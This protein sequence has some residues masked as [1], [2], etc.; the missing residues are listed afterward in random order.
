[1]PGHQV[2]FWK[3]AQTASNLKGRGAKLAERWY[4]P[5]V[6]IGHEWDQAASRD[7][8]WVSYGGR[9][10]LVAGTHLR[11]AEQE[12]CLSHDKFIDE[13]K[14]AFDELKTPTF[15]YTDVRREQVTPGQVMGNVT[16]NSGTE[17]L[18]PES[19]ENL[20]G[21]LMSRLAGTVPD[22]GILYRQ[23]SQAPSAI[24]SLNEHGGMHEVGG[25][26][27]SGGPSANVPLATPRTRSPAV[28]SPSRNPRG[29]DI[30]N[31]D[32][33]ASVAEPA[34][35]PMAPVTPGDP[36]QDV[37]KVGSGHRDAMQA[38]KDLY[39]NA[40]NQRVFS[41][42]GNNHVLIVDELRSECYFLKWKTFNKMQRK[43]RE[44]DPRYFD[45]AE[46]L[47][48]AKSDAKE[49]QSFLDTGAVEVVSP[50]LARDI[51]QKRIFGRPMRFVRTNKNKEENGD[52][53]AKSRIV[54]PGD[55]DPDGDIP[56]EA[57]GFRTD[58]PT[59]PQIAFH[60]LCSQACLKKRQLG[61]LDCKTAFLT[62]RKHDRDIYCRPPK[63]GLPGV[64]PG[65]LL[66]IV[67]GAYG[68][69]EA[70]RLWYLKARD[71]LLDAG[72][73]EMQTA[74]ACFVLHDR[75]E[76]EPVNVGMLVLHVDDACYAG[77]GPMFEKAMEHIRSKFTIGKEEHG[78]FTFLG[79]RVKQ[80][81][82]FSVEIDQHDYV[83]ALERVVVAR[84][85]RQQ[86]TSPL[87]SKELHDYRSLVGQL[88]W[89]AR[90]TMP[91]LAYAVS[92]LQQKVAKATVG[93]L[94]HANNVLNVAKRSVQQN[95][96]LNFRDIGETPRMELQHSHRPTKKS[97]PGRLVKGLGMA[98][99]H[100]ASF[101]GQPNDG[102]QSAYCLMLCSTKMYEG[103]AKTHLLDWGSSKI[104][105]KMR[106]TLACEAASAARA[107]D[108]GAYARS[109][110]YEIENGWTHKWQRLDPDDNHLRLRWEDLCKQIP[111][112]LG[113]DCKSLYDVCT[114]NGSM[115][116]ERR[117]A[118]DLLD[119]RES[120]E[121]MGD[122]IRW[123]PTD[124]MLVDCM[125]KN[126]PPDSML[127]YLRKM[128]YSFKYDD[129][130][131][132]TKREV[133]KLR[134]QQREKK[135]EDS[136]ID[137]NEDTYDSYDTNHVNV[138]DDYS[139]YYPLFNYWYG[140][141]LEKPTLLTY[142]GDYKNLRE[143]HG[144]RK[145]YGILVSQLCTGA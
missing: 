142:V 127:D 111:F 44:L 71:T 33:T 90:E 128:E 82:D 107:F 79:R 126:M 75:K 67:K 91:Q 58:A 129:I 119:V 72:F 98:A 109:M 40:A 144:Y 102:S 35:E 18:S 106:S 42:R 118:L 70:P 54:T 50:E 27:G 45:E 88:A 124:H 103:K 64:A 15:T 22:G 5:G 8:Y 138:V 3:K 134:R 26:T 55:V 68:L 34:A 61:T 99:V 60:L 28:N 43:G 9:C 115:P 145:M 117:V 80:N 125:T 89:P 14:K 130:L 53:E 47:A 49:W 136:L 114:K 100:D 52:L 95:Q 105:R 41:M 65:S 81:S 94:V 29:P 46:K 143:Q 92:D 131:K 51:P 16:G 48:F 86:S 66:K 101:M 1:M 132:N 6:I 108:R 20:S 121:E 116:D 59:C 112:A 135:K 122:K 37:L 2:F 113:T 87:T 62:G 13:M 69:R 97:K 23:T 110:L 133:A 12:E 93:D 73:E 4:G 17:N 139:T 63:D 32:D 85:R 123:I 25:S 39:E 30:R 83:K 120:I 76:S 56:V 74:R 84:E 11:H 78:E 57:G 36:E 7:S 77:E 21:G 24:I 141:T 38:D 19:T 96:K 140:K 10:F 104:H 137:L 31:P